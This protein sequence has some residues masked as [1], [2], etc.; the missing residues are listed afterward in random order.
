MMIIFEGVEV[1]VVDDVDVVDC[2]QYL[3]ILE[4]SVETIGEMR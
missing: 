1:V 2:C 4:E 3:M